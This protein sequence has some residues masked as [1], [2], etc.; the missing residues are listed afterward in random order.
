[1][2]RVT[3]LMI[4]SHSPSTLH[5][6]ISAGHLKSETKELNKKIEC[7]KKCGIKMIHISYSSPGQ[8]WSVRV[9]PCFGS[10]LFSSSCFVLLFLLCRLCERERGDRWRTPLPSGRQSLRMQAHVNHRLSCEGSCQWRANHMAWH[11]SWY[12]TLPAIEMLPHCVSERA[13]GSHTRKKAVCRTYRSICSRSPKM[14]WT[15]A[16]TSQ[17]RFQ[18]SPPAAVSWKYKTHLDLY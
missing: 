13:R 7:Q 17:R 6:N 18:S 4:T 9:L 15:H 11:H 2:Y 10:H 3:T 14:I 16:R 1:M 5:N 12:V 8:Q